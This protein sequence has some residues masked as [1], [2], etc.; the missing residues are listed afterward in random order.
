MKKRSWADAGF[1]RAEIEGND[2][3]VMID[4]RLASEPAAAS[5]ALA[6]SE[7]AARHGILEGSFV[8]NDDGSFRAWNCAGEKVAA[9][10]F[11]AQ[12]GKRVKAYAARYPDGTL[13]RALAEHTARARALRLRLRLAPRRAATPRRPSTRPAPR[14]SRRVRRAAPPVARS[15]EEPPAGEGGDAP[16][17]VRRS[18]HE[19]GAR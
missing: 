5:D 19:R 6:L 4:I 17:P 10:E 1:A 16:Q 3:L 9:A 12:Q 11:E 7:L 13:A 18:A 8:Q 15:P 14:A 2:S